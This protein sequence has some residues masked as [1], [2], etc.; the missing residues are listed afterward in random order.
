MKT[1]ET[2]IHG[3]NAVLALLKDPHRVVPT[4]TVVDGSRNPRLHEVVQLARNRQA[5]LRF[6][7]R[8]SLDRLTGCKEHQGVAAHVL[9]RPQP[10]WSDLVEQLPR[11][12]APL[13]LL[14]DGIEDPH[15]LGA[16]LRSAA[17]F[18]VTAVVQT[19][20]RCAPLTPAAEK[21]AAGAT[22]HIDLVRVTNLAQA[23]EELRQMFI[24]IYGLEGLAETTLSE[25]DLTS[26]LALVMGGESN[27]L[28]RLTREKCDRLL[29]IPMAGG[30]GSLNVSVATGVAL[31][32]AFRQ[33]KAGTL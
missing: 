10:Q 31:Y 9:P 20:D 13:L 6:V 18:G 21:A 11:L 14:L 29:A 30:V 25:V 7:D 4:V 33:R 32:E 19:R 3:I 26:P 24:P 12:P 15:N 17:A 2:W 5:R 1:P 28:R 27:G 8:P 16:I 23:L 22:A